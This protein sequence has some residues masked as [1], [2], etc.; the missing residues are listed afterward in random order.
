[1]FLGLKLGPLADTPAESHFGVWSDNKLRS[2]C[3]WRRVK[4][5]QSALAD[6]VRAALWLLVKAVRSYKIYSHKGLHSRRFQVNRA[7][8]LHKRSHRW[9]G[10]RLHKCNRGCVSLGSWTDSRNRLRL[11][12]CATC[13]GP[14][15]GRTMAQKR[16]RNTSATTACEAAPTSTGTAFRRL[17]CFHIKKKGSGCRGKKKLSQLIWAD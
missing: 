3:L 11:A 12:R 7:G 13:C 9:T 10:Y 2:W 5:E 6:R 17:K 16:P 4:G 15:P 8:T 1:M 14:T